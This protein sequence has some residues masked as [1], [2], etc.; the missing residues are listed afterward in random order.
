[1]ADVEIIMP[2]GAFGASDFDDALDTAM[3]EIAVRASTDPEGEWAEKYGTA[4]ENDEFMMRPYCWC[5]RDDCRWCSEDACGCEHLNPWYEWDGE[6]V[7]WDQV[8]AKLPPH[9]L[10]HNVA[11][12]GTPEYKKA[13]AA[14]EAAMSFRDAHLAQWWPARA[15]TCEPSGMMADREQG[16]TWLPSQSAPNFWHKPSGFK[17]WWYKYI[18]RDMET[19]GTPPVDLLERCLASLPN[20]GLSSDPPYGSSATALNPSE[21]GRALR[22]AVPD[23]YPTPPRK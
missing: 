4:V 6:R 15:H 7:T 17:V 11:K 3:R 5:E 22:A 19:H 2:A 8:Q 23:P 9:D 20:A 16:Y 1:M 12:H 18:G 14:F 21:G 13:T 10:P